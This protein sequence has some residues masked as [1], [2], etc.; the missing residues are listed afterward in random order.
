MIPWI[1]KYAPKKISEIIGQNK[2]ITELKLFLRVFPKQKAALLYGPTGAGKTVT[3]FA[4]AN[5]NQLDIVELNASDFRDK[6]SILQILEPAATQSTIWGRKK[7]ILIDEIDNLSGQQD[8]GGLPAILEVIKKTK[9]PILLTANDPFQQKLKTLRQNCMLIEFKKLKTQDIVKCLKQICKSEKINSSERALQKIAQHADG[10]LRAAINDLQLFSQGKKELCEH[11][12]FDWEREREENI[13]SV[14]RVIFKSYDTANALKLAD[15][16]NLDLDALLLWLDQNIPF[17]YTN[18]K[19]LLEAYKSLSDADIFL[20]RILH[21]QHW[22]FLIYAQA[23]AVVGVQQA[24]FSINRKFII[25]RRPELL[26]KLY[27][28]AAKRKKLRGL[29]EQISE[30]LHT[31]SSILMRSFWPY[32]FFI[33]KQNPEFAKKLNQS[34]GLEKL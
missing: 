5:E 28:R 12:V 11:D 26:L 31:S 9:F 32:F 14:L 34:L 10:D 18:Y 23:L 22:R 20:A 33:Q 8:R 4:L 3:V 25:H 7:I 17:E 30:K 2:A 19:E 15:T 27:I 21:W 13:F 16:L 24:K 6:Q 29:S 1:K